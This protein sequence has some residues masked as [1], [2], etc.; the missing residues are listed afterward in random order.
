[1]K[2]DY[3][4]THSRIQDIFRLVDRELWI[5]TAAT[6]SRRGGLVATWVAQASLDPESPV[7]LIAIA[8]NHFTAELIN[9]CGRFAAHLIRGDQIDLVW[10][11]ALSSGRDQDKLQGLPT[12]QAKTGAPVLS[13]CIAWLDCR[14]ITSYD[15][16]D[17][18][19]YW[20][21]VVD[22]GRQ[23]DATPLCEK[24][25]LARSS[26]EQRDHLRQNILD[27]I[28]V[29]KPMLADWRRRIGPT[30]A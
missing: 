28:E 24:D 13:D 16:G 5:V 14:V 3:S 27:D 22:S 1:M 12:I 15:S 8:A 19:F 18:V 29:Q 6:E 11:F 21:D 4:S 2:P 10:R 25:M 20:A 30:E 17:R 9:E 7:V 26:P 23:D